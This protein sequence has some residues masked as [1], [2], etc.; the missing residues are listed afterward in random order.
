MSIEQAKAI[1]I[2]PYITEKSFNLIEREN[3]LTF[4]VAEKASKKEVIEALSILYEAEAAHVNTY[5]TIYGK[6]ALLKFK[7]PDAAR[8]LATTLGLV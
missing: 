6:K 2:K 7:N 8:D 3:K 1:L 5:R 4:L